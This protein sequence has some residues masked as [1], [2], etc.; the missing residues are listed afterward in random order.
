MAAPKT[1]PGKKCI[2]CGDTAVFTGMKFIDSYPHKT[3]T[4]PTC[5]NKYQ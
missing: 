3:Y 5:G 1:E 4:C 2:N